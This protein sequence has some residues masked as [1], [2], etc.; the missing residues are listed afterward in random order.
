MGYPDQ[1]DSDWYYVGSGRGNFSK[2]D[3]RGKGKGK[4]NGKGKGKNVKGGKGKSGG[5]KGGKSAS[6]T[7]GLVESWTCEYCFAVHPVF[8]KFCLDCAPQQPAT[9]TPPWR[10]DRGKERVN[11]WQRRDNISTS[12]TRKS[13]VYDGQP[14]PSS[15][16]NGGVTREQVQAWLK[17]QGAND[18]V[19]KEVEGLRKAEYYDDDD[20]D[21]DILR[22]LQSTTSKLQNIE[23]AIQQ[24]DARVVKATELLGD[25]QKN[26]DA[27][28]DKRNDLEEE[29][30]NI[31]SSF[32]GDSFECADVSRLGH[33]E[34]LL[35]SIAETV[36]A[37]N[38]QHPGLSRTLN[39]L[40]SRSPFFK[41]G[42]KEQ[43][44]RGAT[45]EHQQQGG[46]VT[47]HE[48]GDEACVDRTGFG[49]GPAAGPLP[50]RMEEPASG[51]GGKPPQAE[52]GAKPY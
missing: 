40:L 16:G 1:Y 37:E 33:Y 48:S 8:H 25:A 7:D 38:P 12:Q 6:R 23:K 20:V 43:G 29:L 28:L 15:H 42:Q 4:P 14:A 34:Q 2:I 31:K 50:P 32:S 45:I 39:E 19:M 17:E 26:R 35:N 9:P 13:N 11:R 30:K 5:K 51:K 46:G 36:M 47:Q 24:A 44:G 41:V 27:L 3:G 22:D 52:N 21:K 49:F 18:Q 10:S